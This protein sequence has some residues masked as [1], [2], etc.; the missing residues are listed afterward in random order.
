MQAGDEALIEGPFVEIRRNA[1]VP[2]S[3]KIQGQAFV[4]TGV[5]IGDEVFV[6]PGDALIKLIIADGV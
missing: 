1:V 3:C 4:C 2:A 5:E 6:R